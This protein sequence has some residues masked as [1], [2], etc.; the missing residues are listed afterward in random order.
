MAAT[1]GGDEAI[2]CPVFR[3]WNPSHNT[4]GGILTCRESSVDS[5]RDGTD[6]YVRDVSAETLCAKFHKPF[7]RKR[8]GAQ[9]QHGTVLICESVGVSG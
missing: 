5:G 8:A 7:P 4:L 9:Q 1:L 2:S 6:Y 3:T